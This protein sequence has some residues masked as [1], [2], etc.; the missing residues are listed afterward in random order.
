MR[1]ISRRVGTEK[2]QVGILQLAT[3]KPHPHWQVRPSETCEFVGFS[4]ANVSRET[5]T[6]SGEKT[7]KS[8]TTRNTSDE[9]RVSFARTESITSGGVGKFAH[10][11]RLPAER[12]CDCGALA[13][14]RPHY[15]NGAK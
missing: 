15:D 7:A 13:H 8:A 10:I 6:S 14:V 12:G 1:S 9:A 5:S 4:A 2:L 3:V 11:G